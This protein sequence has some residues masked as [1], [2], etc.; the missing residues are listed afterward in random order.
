MQLPLF[1]FGYSMHDI[2]FSK[3]TAPVHNSNAG[4][5]LS[6]P[7]LLLPNKLFDKFSSTNFFHL[8]HT[9]LAKWTDS[10][11]FDAVPIN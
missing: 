7:L 3:T 9:F 4:N 10:Q 2:Q 6:K 5:I 11:W 8:S 1:S